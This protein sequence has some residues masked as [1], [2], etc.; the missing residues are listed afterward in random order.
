MK[1]QLF[2]P[3][4]YPR[5]PKDMRPG[6]AEGAK[7]VQ[8]IKIIGSRNELNVIHVLEVHQLPNA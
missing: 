4:C 5:L 7:S 6:S 2:T 8:C 1:E 3:C